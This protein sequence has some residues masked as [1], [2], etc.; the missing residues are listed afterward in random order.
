[1]VVYFWAS[2]KTQ[3]AHSSSK[4]AFSILSA[5]VHNETLSVI[6]VCVH[7]PDCSPLAIQRR[8]PAQAPSGFAEMLQYGQPAEPSRQSSA[9]RWPCGRSSPMRSAMQSATQ[10]FSAAHSCVIRVYDSAGNVIETHERTG[11]F[12][13]CS[14]PFSGAKPA[15]SLSRSGGD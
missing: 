13:E 5:C 3:I 4:N 10:R 9:S 6:A 1:M 15:R 14:Q 12:K 8:Y 11:D 2:G 7:D